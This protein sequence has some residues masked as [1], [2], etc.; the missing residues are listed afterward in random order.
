MP[1]V[2]WPLEEAVGFYVPWHEAWGQ[3]VWSSGWLSKPWLTHREEEEN[4]WEESQS[5]AGFVR[6]D[7]GPV[8]ATVS[9]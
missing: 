5:R 7:R 2:H 3:L 4:P 6:V 1:S 8:A 9:S